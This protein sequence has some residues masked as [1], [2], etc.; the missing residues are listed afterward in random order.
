MRLPKAIFFITSVIVSVSCSKV[1]TSVTSLSKAV[2]TVSFT[3]PQITTPNGTIDFTIDFENDENS[4]SN[5]QVFYC[6][7]TD[8]PSCSPN[9]LLGAM[10]R[11][12]GSFT[13]EAPQ[14]SSPDDEGDTLNLR[15]VGTDSDG[16]IN[17]TSFDA[18]TVVPTNSITVSNLVISN[19]V[20]DGF[21][22]SFDYLGD[23]NLNAVSAVSYCN[24]TDSP[25]CLPTN[26][27]VVTTNRQ[28]S[29]YEMTVTGLSAPDHPGDE[30]NISINLTD[31]DGT[32]GAPLTTTLSLRLLPI[33]VSNLQFSNF[34]AGGFDANIDFNGDDNSNSVVS[35]LYCNE[36]DS[37]GCTPTFSPTV[38]ITRLSS[39]I[40]LQ[41]SGLASPND[42][43]D[44]LNIRVTATDADGS[45]GGPLNGPVTLPI[46]DIS[47]SNMLVGNIGEQSFSVSVDYSNDDNSNSTLTLYYCNLTD[48]PACSPSTSLG[49]LTRSDSHF[50]KSIISS[51]LLVSDNPG[52]S[53]KIQVVTADADGVSGSPQS[54]TFNL[55]ASGGVDH[56][57]RSVGPGNTLAL[58]S[59]GSNAL[60][61]SASTATFSSS[62]ALNVGVGDAIQYDSDGNSS[63]DS[64]AFI[65]ARLSSTT[66]TVYNNLGAMPTPTTADQDWS[67]FRSHTSLNDAR[68]GTENTGI[69]IAV[70]N[71]NAWSFSHDIVASNQVW[72]LALYAD[73][74]DTSAV[75]LNG[76][77]TSDKNYLRI[78]APSSQFEVG[79]SQRHNGVWDNTKARLEVTNDRNLYILDDHVIV[80]GIQFRSI[81][82]NSLSSRAAIQTGGGNL[83]SIIIRNNIIRGEMTGS[84]SSIW[85]VRG[86]NSNASS[87][88]YIVNNII[89]GFDYTSGLGVYGSTTAPVYVYNNSVYNCYTGYLVGGNTVLKNNFAQNSGSRG[90]Q[91]SA[92][93]ASDYNISDLTDA[94]G[95]NSQNSVSLTFVDAVNG[96]F[97]LVAG[98]TDAIGTGVSLLN[99]SFFPFSSDITGAERNGPWDIGAFKY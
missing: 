17:G 22:I 67:I 46:N 49:T 24:E 51:D 3:N 81:I 21:E 90:Y 68:A 36:T 92:S 69:D 52:D 85:G 31:A 19:I 83:A 8:N 97:N 75:L 7:E 72:H 56:I 26:P 76:W 25:G 63:I 88:I 86:F 10:V 87:K 1:S 11:G 80:E 96:N 9:I 13:F 41:V 58:D 98:D 40:R 29:T 73:A 27:M 95:G 44:T 61:I 99:D 35:L 62:I 34:V 38:A 4:N 48:S 6:N 50:Y 74:A 55:V 47:V 18:T 43:G 37:P 94:P 5:V 42:A 79:V 89:Y 66:Y 20:E 15:V 54:Y 59:G 12:D 33:V 77:T 65:H 70:R 71:F 57:Y 60:T 78:F 14:F 84:G 23:E 32:N 82:N 2:N 64:I 53:L 93:A 91:G 16:V 28:S 45:S 39:S 30:L